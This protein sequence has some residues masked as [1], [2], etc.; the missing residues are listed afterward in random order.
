MFICLRYRAVSGFSGSFFCWTLCVCHVFSDEYLSVSKC[1][2]LPGITTLECTISH[3]LNIPAR[4]KLHTMWENSYMLYQAY[5]YTHGPFNHS[6]AQCF[7]LSYLALR[8][9]FTLYL[10]ALTELR[11]LC[12]RLIISLFMNEGKVIYWKVVVHVYLIRLAAHF[13]I[14]CVF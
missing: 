10:L 5:S 6:A 8:W 9:G 1:C 4:S 14:R 3:R 12:N 2:R 11:D 7:C 13:L